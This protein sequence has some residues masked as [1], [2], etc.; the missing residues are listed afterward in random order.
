MTTTSGG[1]ERLCMG[2]PWNHR[3]STYQSPTFK[4]RERLLKGLSQKPFLLKDIILNYKFSLTILG[5][6]L[7]SYPRLSSRSN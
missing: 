6:G 7:H 2:T 5:M 3:E 1:S 4:K